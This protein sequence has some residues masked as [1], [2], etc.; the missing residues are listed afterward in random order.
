MDILVIGG[1]RLLGLTLVKQLLAANN[2]ITVL[3]RHPEKCPVGVVECIGAER[4]EGLIQLSGREFDMTV[5]FIAYDEVA[6]TQV[7]N[8]FN[9]GV[10]ILISSTWLVRLAPFIA[11]NQPVT[12]VDDVCTRLLPDI[13][14][15]YLVGKMR[16]EAS[17]FEMRKRNS[18]AT[19]LRLPIFWGRREHTDRLNFYCQRISDGAPVICVNGGN[20]YAQIAWD[21]DV[22]RVVVSWLYRAAEH[23][24]W[25]AIPNKGTKVQDIIGLIAVGLG[26]Q[27][28]LVNV[29]S[30]QLSTDLPDYLTEEPLWRETSINITES[31]LFTVMGTT[32][33]MQNKWL[34]NL[35]RDEMITGISEL[36]KK[37]IIFLEKNFNDTK[38]IKYNSYN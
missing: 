16:A 18:S 12:L 11:A 26:K 10:Y 33:T 36:R 37:E 15:S 13:T 28:T 30:K 3:S 1:T 2:N 29:S 7:F 38:F 14:Y 35:A 23:S 31:N 34:C 5:D 32:P 19:I 9:P 24:I 20:N 22:A 4:E 21:E 25:E 27:P 8:C 17:V 6:P